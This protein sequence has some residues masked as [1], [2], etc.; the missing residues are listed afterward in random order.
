M[1]TSLNR[2]IGTPAVWQDRQV[3]LVESAVADG[4][5]GMLHGLLVR[6]GLGCAR[7]SP[8]EEIVL[9]GEHCVVLAAAPGRMPELQPRGFGRAFLTAGQCA[10][11]VTDAVLQ[12]ETL[13]IA[14]L[15]ISPG[16]VYRLLGRCVYAR[17]YRLA[18]DGVM[19]PALL[20]WSQLMSRL[21]EECT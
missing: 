20:T 7:W 14:A 10:G 4:E 21:K 2:L 15:E 5:S 13:R 12:G 6:K 3:G 11:T 8:R 16:P 9:A 1:L 18:A 19:V 17:E